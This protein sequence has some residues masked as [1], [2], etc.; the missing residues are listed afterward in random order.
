M[1]NQQRRVVLWLGLIMMLTLIL[2]ASVAC[3][4]SPLMDLIIENQ[5]TQVLTVYVDDHEVGDV[6]LGGQITWADA[7]GNMS[8]YIIEAKNTK[9][10]TVFS[11][12]F[13]FETKDKYHLQQIKDGVYKAVI[14]PLQSN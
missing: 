2:V 14:P 9:G 11:E 5:T 3:W 12:T 10:E 6:G 8:R 7:P 4:G 13:T 1:E